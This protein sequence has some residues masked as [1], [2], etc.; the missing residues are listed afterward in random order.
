VFAA[1]LAMPLGMALATGVQAPPNAIAQRAHHAHVVLTFR[2]ARAIGK[3]VSQRLEVAVE[4]LDRE[5]VKAQQDV[6]DGAEV[7]QVAFRAVALAGR[8]PSP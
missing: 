4:L 2:V 3:R 5:D 6:G 7:G 1:V 8:L